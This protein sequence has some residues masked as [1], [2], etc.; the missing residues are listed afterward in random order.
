MWRETMTRT[1][2]HDIMPTTA[3]CSDRIEQVARRQEG[4]AGQDVEA[5]P[6][7]RHD[8]QH[9]E[10]PNIESGRRRHFIR[11]DPRPYRR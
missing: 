6:N 9:G 8:Q 4:S 2:P 1:M 10:Q 5:D 3:T 11:Y 7:G